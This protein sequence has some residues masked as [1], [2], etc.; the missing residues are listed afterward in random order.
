MASC[1]S[2]SILKNSH[3]ELPA[4]VQASAPL[5]IEPVYPPFSGPAREPAVPL[6]IYGACPGECCGYGQ[7]ST[8]EKT[9]VYVEA[10]DTDHVLLQLPP[11][12]DIVGLGGFVYLTRLGTAEA[13]REIRTDWDSET[14]KHLT[15]PSNARVAVLDHFGEGIWRTWYAG[16]IYQLPIDDSREQ[17]TQFQDDPYKGM[18]FVQPSVSQWWALVRLPNDGR[19]GWINMNESPL[20]K[21]VD[22]CGG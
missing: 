2:C 10:L 11:A 5:T 3:E 4:H 15:I 12:T 8:T 1:A 16:R 22:G 19:I 20:I 7:W 17:A 14:Q 18:V 9:T 21:G 13:T 6:R